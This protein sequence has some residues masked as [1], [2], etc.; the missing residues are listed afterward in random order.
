VG[1]SNGSSGPFKGLL[2]PSAVAG[3]VKAVRV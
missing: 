1:A 3:A 2:K